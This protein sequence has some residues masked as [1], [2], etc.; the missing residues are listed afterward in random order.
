ML[1]HLTTLEGHQNSIYTLVNMP[2]GKHILSAGNDKGIVQWSLNQMAFSKIIKPVSSSVYNLHINENLLFIAYR[3]GLIEVFS[4]T[5]LRLLKRLE[6]H[7]KSV[8]DI[9]S[10]PHKKEII[11]VGEDGL[12]NI[13]SLE[14]LEHLY[15]FQAVNTTI[16]AIA[17]SNDEKEIALG[18]KDNVIRIYNTYDYSLKQ[19][20]RGHTRP[21]TSL[22]YHP[23]QEQLLSGSRDA[24]LKVWDLK[25]YQEEKSIAAHLFTI[26]GIEFH[27]VLP[28]LA[29]ASQ[30][31][32]IKIWDSKEYRLVKILSLEKNGMG[33]THSVNKITWSEDGRYLVS[34]GDDKKVIVW[35]FDEGI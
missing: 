9:A 18:C 28:Y 23:E 10:I 4:L 32:S 8:F 19:E 24:Q 22:K 15:Q 13:W 17:I 6:K 1:K 25:T 7:I 31:K 3:S 16:R 27:P 2:D 11:S 35:T 26:Y 21:I 20:L 33:H 30:D 5:E 14:S 12:V 34:T 29:T